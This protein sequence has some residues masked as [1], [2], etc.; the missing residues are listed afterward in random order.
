MKPETKRRERAW[1]WQTAN[2]PDSRQFPEKGWQAL[3]NP[4]ADL[5]GE[6]KIPFPGFQQPSNAL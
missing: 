3:S 1:Q 5:S 4:L 2:K 6:V